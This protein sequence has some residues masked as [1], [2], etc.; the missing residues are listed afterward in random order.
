MRRFSLG[1]CG[2]A[3]L[4]GVLGLI[5]SAWDCFSCVRI[6]IYDFS[7][8]VRSKPRVKRGAKYY[9]LLRSTDTDQDNIFAGGIHVCIRPVQY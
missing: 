3:A 8:F 2:E 1:M 7:N 5:S 4:C 9:P 6:S